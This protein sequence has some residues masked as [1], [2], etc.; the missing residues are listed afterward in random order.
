[1]VRCGFIS[2]ISGD[3]NQRHV[4]VVGYL[5]DEAFFGHCRA[6]PSVIQTGSN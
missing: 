1:M 3:C 6:S 5:F 4:G 2:L